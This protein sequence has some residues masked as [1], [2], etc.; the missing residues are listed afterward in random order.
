MSDPFEPHYCNKGRDRDR[1]CP[2]YH[3]C[4]GATG[5]Y[6]RVE[7]RGKGRIFDADVQVHRS[8]VEA[9]WSAVLAADSDGAPSSSA[10]SPALV[11]SRHA[12]LHVRRAG[13]YLVGAV[14]RDVPP[15]LVLELLGRIADVFELYFREL[16]EEALRD[17]FVTAY[18]L[19][20]EMVDHGVPVHTEPVS[21]THLTL[22]TICSV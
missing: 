10:P 20:D 22:P 18:Q 14:E 4:S 3:D 9:F 16:S 1:L 17:N 13:L 2:V 11:V 21:Y 15:L 7:L 5:K 19:L 6:V 8:V 12:L